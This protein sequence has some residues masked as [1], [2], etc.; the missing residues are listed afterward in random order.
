MTGC[1]QTILCRPDADNHSSC[2]TMTVSCPENVIFQLPFLSFYPLPLREG[3]V[4]LRSIDVNV[5]FR[6]EYL[7][8][9]IAMN[10]NSYKSLSLP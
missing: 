10:L 4:N 9:F 8:V 7:D 5:L 1:S 3:S 6:S 2:K